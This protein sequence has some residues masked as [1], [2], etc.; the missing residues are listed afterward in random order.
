MRRKKTAFSPRSPKWMAAWAK[1]DVIEH[2]QR[3]RDR[4][5]GSRPRRICR[6]P[7]RRLI[8]RLRYGRKQVLK[9]II[10]GPHPGK[11]SPYLRDRTCRVRFR[12]LPMPAQWKSSEVKDAFPLFWRGEDEYQ[13][14]TAGDFHLSAHAAEPA[15]VESVDF[16]DSRISRQQS[17]TDFTD[18]IAQR[19][20]C[21]KPSD[22]DSIGQRI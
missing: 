20:D 2:T 19:A 8:Q 7:D 3:P 17:H 14:L 11:K 15:G 12:R 16:T 1:G 22:C 21:P 9:V 13:S 6:N 18:R 10:D 4:S 5:P